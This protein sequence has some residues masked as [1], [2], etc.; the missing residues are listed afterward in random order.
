[1]DKEITIAA[2]NDLLEINNDRIVGYQTAIKDTVDSDLHTIFNKFLHTSE[3][4]ASELRVEI[5]NLGGEKES[6]TKN[7][8]KLHR[9]WMEFKT[10]LTVNDRG[11]VLNSCEF[12][13]GEALKIYDETLENNLQNLD[14]MLQKMI[15]RQHSIIKQES[16]AITTL[17]NVAEVE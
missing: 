4:F 10:L 7:T 17:K 5:G 8:G 1:M 16:D 2:L 12:G 14:P 9:L 11:A 13:D 15:M 3:T 6:G